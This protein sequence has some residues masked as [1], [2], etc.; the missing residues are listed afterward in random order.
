MMLTGAGRINGGSSCSLDIPSHARSSTIK[1][2]TGY[3]LFFNLFFINPLKL[4]F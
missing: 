4:A 1:N 2:K 3:A